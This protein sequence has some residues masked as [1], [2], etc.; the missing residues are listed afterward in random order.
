MSSRLA[1]SQSLARRYRSRP[2]AAVSD[3]AIW[4]ANLPSA[5]SYQVF[6]RWTAGANRAVSA[7]YQVIH[8]GGT[9]T[10]NVNQ[11]ANGGAWQLLGT[12]NFNAGNNKVKLS[13]WTAAGF[14]V[15]ADGVK[16]VKQ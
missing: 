10:V 8:T 13:C 4:T 14:Y 7:P 3:A 15:I 9:A 5:G 16:F 1:A 2:T 11:Q 12:Y 6:A